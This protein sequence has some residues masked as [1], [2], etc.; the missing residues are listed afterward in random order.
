MTNI[1]KEGDF[2]LI[3]KDKFQWKAL[4]NDRSDIVCKKP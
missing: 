3:F 2:N 4:D 1:V